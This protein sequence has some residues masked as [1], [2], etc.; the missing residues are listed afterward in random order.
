MSVTMPL[1]RIEG[2]L[3]QPSPRGAQVFLWGHER[4]G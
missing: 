2:V 3:D 1:T 4:A